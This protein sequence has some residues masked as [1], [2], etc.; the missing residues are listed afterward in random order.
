MFPRGPDPGGFGY[1][2][3]D[4]LFFIIRN[5]AL[6]EKRSRVLQ[7]RLFILML[8]NIIFLEE[9]EFLECASVL[10]VPCPFAS[11]CRIRLLDMIRERCCRQDSLVQRRNNCYHRATYCEK[12]LSEYADSGRIIVLRE[13]ARHYSMKK[14]RIND[15][16]RRINI[17][18]TN[19]E[20]ARVLDLPKGSVDS[21]LYYLKDFL[22]GWKDRCSLP[23]HGK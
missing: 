10:G 2:L 11:C 3:S 21:G 22:A 1:D 18:P 6:P 9:G 16:I 17:L 13:N 5:A 7:T 15:Q 20:I 12:Q 14:S 4:K 19:R 8:K 23:D